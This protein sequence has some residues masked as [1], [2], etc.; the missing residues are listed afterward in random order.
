MAARPARTSTSAARRGQAAKASRA[1]LSARA[2]LASA[3]ARAAARRAPRRPAQRGGRVRP[4]GQRAGPA[5][6]GDE[7]DSEDSRILD[8]AGGDAGHPGSGD[9]GAEDDG[10]LLGQPV[11]AIA[12]LGAHMVRVRLMLGGRPAPGVHRGQGGGDCGDR[13]GGGA[14]RQGGEGDGDRAG[15]GAA[16]PG[17]PVGAMALCRAAGGIPRLFF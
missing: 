8:P 12:Q 4:L 9:E 17:Q 3:R 11:G 2:A 7:S 14:A 10:A 1:R 16:L 15:G 13:A 6:G 5:D